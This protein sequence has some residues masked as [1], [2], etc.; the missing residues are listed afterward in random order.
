MIATREKAQGFLDLH[1][2]PN[3]L[4]LPNAWDVASAV[5][6]SRQG[7][8]AIATTSAG[9]GFSHGYVDG[10]SI[11]RAEV[12]EEMR[13]MIAHVDIPI[14]A[15]LEAGYGRDPAIVAETVRQAIGVGVVGCNLEDSSKGDAKDKGRPLFDVDFAVERCRAAR[16]AADSCGIPFVLNARVDCFLHYGKGPEVVAAAI[17]RGNAYVE[18]GATCVFIP[19]VTSAAEI[20]LL[21]K[22]I[23]APL[24]VLAAPGIP[25]VQEL[26]DLGVARLT[27]GSSLARVGYAEAIRVAR[28]LRSSGVFALPPGTISNPELTHLLS[29]ASM[30]TPD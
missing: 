28:E 1:H 30:K 7:F 13:R 14:T 9:I 22:E 23:G 12:M 3:I 21:V 16:E 25:T 5:L 11:P 18:A 20:R 2:G 26:A 24:N 29:E 6:L 15:D 4:V 10:E 17:Q 27:L 8:P 19:R